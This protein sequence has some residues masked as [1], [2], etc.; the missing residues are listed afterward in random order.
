[1]NLMA[2]P[3]AAGSASGERADMSGEGSAGTGVALAF[4]CNH[5]S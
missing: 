5:A 1:M 3:G 2:E 4:P